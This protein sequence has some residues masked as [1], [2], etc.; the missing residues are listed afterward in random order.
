MKHINV[1]GVCIYRNAIAYPFE[2]IEAS[3][4]LNISTD[5][6][7]DWSQSTVID[8]EG[9]VFI[10]DVRTNQ[11]MF[12]PAPTQKGD[13]S[14]AEVMLA[15]KIHEC[16]LPCLQHFNN[17]F[18]LSIKSNSTLGYQILKYSIGEHYVSHLD[19]GERTRRYASA[20]AY[21]NDDYEGGELYFQD[22]N[23]T[24]EPVAGDVVI[25]PSGAPFRHEAKPVISGTKYSIANW[26]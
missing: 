12:T 26:W 25:F 1:N 2:I 17:K 3:E 23:F 13:E 18:G 8:T 15:N 24:Y 10:S 14:S 19:N 7:G 5:S 6:K 11:L 21:L 22:L 16:V 4:L 9:K 20:V